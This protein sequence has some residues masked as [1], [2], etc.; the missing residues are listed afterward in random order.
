MPNAAGIRPLTP[1]EVPH[2]HLR[3]HETA[4]RVSGMQTPEEAQVVPRLGSSD[5]AEVD[6]PGIATAFVEDVRDVEVAVDEHRAN[7]AVPDERSGGRSDPGSLRAGQVIRQRV[8]AGLDPLV[9]L[10]VEPLLV[11]PMLGPERASPEV[12]AN[13]SESFDI[14]GVHDREISTSRPKNR[15][16]LATVQ[17]WAPADRLARNLSQN[18]YGSADVRVDRRVRDHPRDLAASLAQCFVNM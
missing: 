13:P 14:Y 18:G 11:R 5:L 2:D 12:A 8:E 10:A 16:E 1:F 4:D 17:S 9:G 3:I 6:Q 15:G 7:L